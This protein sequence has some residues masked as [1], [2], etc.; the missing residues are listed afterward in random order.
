M[1]QF[2]NLVVK[3]R[4]PILIVAALLL[5]PSAWGYLHTQV[6]YDL[7]TYLP[8]SIDTVKGQDILKKDFGKGAFSL[9]VT[10]GL[11]DESVADLTEKI[12][13]VDSVDTALQAVTRTLHD[14]MD[15]TTV[16]VTKT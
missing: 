15:F 16:E 7:L 10:E 4:I 8:D 1:R 14:L 6:N 13:D 12:L 9:I 2:G 11:D 5:I 3:M